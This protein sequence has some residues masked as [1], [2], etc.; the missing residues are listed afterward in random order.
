MKTRL[1]ILCGCAAIALAISITTDHVDNGRLAW[2]ASETILAPATLGQF[3]LA[4]SLGIDAPAYAQPLVFPYVLSG[5]SRNVVIAASMNCTVYAFDADTYAQL[6]SNTLCTARA[7]YPDD[8]FFYHKSIGCLATPVADPAHG[9]LYAA[10]V[11]STPNVVLYQIA[12]ATGVVNQSATLSGTYGGLAFSPG[13]SL[14]RMGLTLANGNVYIGFSGYDDE[15]PWNGWIFGYSTNG[16]AQIG[17]FSTTPTGNGGGVWQASG[18]LAVDSSGNL[19]SA[20]GNGTYDGT[21]NFANSIIKLSPS[22]TL[23]DW[24]TPSNFASLSSND[25]DMASG[26]V[27]L[28]PATNLIALGEKDFNVY[29]VDRTCMGHLQGGGSGCTAA[30]VFATNASGVTSHSS[31]IYGG[32]FANGIGYWPNTGGSIYAFTFADGAFTQTPLA[33]STPTYAFPGAQ[34]SVSSNGAS[35]SILWA[36]TFA[37]SPFS[38]PGAGTLRALNASTLAEYWNSGSGNDAL[39]NMTKFTGPVVANGKVFVSTYDNQVQVYGL[40]GSSFRGGKTLAGGK[41]LSQ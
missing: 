1:L 27:M 11:N 26:R 9:F 39:G 19:Y 28:I 32:A 14:P 4:G 34:M 13:Q 15:P 17:L 10:C 20:T 12:I 41:T 3:H 33:I 22:L 30:V 2:N 21:A 6:W 37:S 24:F 31:G 25:L 8:G 16:L 38:S 7:S 23:L 36:A 35:N 5:V 40:S 29:I 18:G